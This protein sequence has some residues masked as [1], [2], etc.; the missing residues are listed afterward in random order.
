MAGT[1]PLDLYT[2]T[3]ALLQASIEALDMIPSF[4]PGLGGAPERAF[5]AN[6][7]PALDCCPMLAVASAPIR[8]APTQ[9]LE[10]GAGTRHQQEFRKNYAG[11]TVW[12][13]RC[14]PTADIIPTAEEMN[15]ISAQTYA[16]SWALWNYLWNRARDRS[17]PLF[18]ICGGVY[19]DTI[20]PITPAG[21][22]YGWSL[23][24]RAELE[25]FEGVPV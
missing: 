16:D 22:C 2:Q 15:D 19:F 14:G 10:M 17:D 12:I 9:P 24:I 6:G 21:G 4:S 25:G 8:E 3:A 11:W 5:I 18:T 7:T 13:I 23:Q 1:G 20:A